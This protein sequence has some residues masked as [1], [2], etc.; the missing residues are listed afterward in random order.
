MILP[1]LVCCILRLEKKFHKILILWDKEG[2]DNAFHLGG[3]GHGRIEWGLSWGWMVVDSGCE[4][5]L[6]NTDTSLTLVR[7]ISTRAWTTV[8]RASSV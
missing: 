2:E 6:S 1:T 8:I 5:L 4:D 7:L 3:L